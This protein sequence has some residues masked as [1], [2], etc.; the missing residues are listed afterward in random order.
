MTP[1]IKLEV[2]GTRHAV[3]LTAI[4]DTGF[5]GD[6]CVPAIVA[7][8]LGLELIGRQPVELADGTV[9]KE[10]VF[11]GKVR[12]LGKSHAVEMLLT[13]SDDALVGT[14]LLSR[15]ILSI[16]FPIC[17]VKVPAQQKPSRKPKRKSR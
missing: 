1:T 10:L 2:H 16:E 5:D 8:S 7:V 14:N 17:Q 3:E 6:V 12:M 4:A 9:K 11:A 15:Y 13:D